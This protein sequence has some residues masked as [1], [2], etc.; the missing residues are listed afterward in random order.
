MKTHEYKIELWN[1]HFDDDRFSYTSVN[2]S[3]AIQSIYTFADLQIGDNITNKLDIIED[4]INN[5]DSQIDKYVSDNMLMIS[6]GDARVHLKRMTLD[7]HHLITRVLVS[8]R[9][10]VDE[11][12]RKLIDIILMDS[13]CV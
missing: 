2:R 1:T 5:I 10:Q 13:S 9:Q 3:K 4:I 12:T 8:A 11:N 6:I 7:N